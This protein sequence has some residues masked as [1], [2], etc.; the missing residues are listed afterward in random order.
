MKVKTLIQ[1]SPTLL[2]MTNEEAL[3]QWNIVAKTY[4]DNND[5]LVEDVLHFK[6][7]DHATL[8][9]QW[10]QETYPDF[11]VIEAKY[12]DTAKKYGHYS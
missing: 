2:P 4:L 1:R 10:F 5:C 9:W 8:V 6:K 3:K 12:A 11:S 7:G